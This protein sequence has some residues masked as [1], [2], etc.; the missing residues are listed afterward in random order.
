MSKSLALHATNCEI[1]PEVMN[2]ELMK[3]E[4]HGLPL[5]KLLEICTNRTLGLPSRAATKA[6][7]ERL[8]VW[9]MAEVESAE[10]DQSHADAGSS[11]LLGCGSDVGC[12]DRSR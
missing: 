3:K 7:S 12:K 1:G 9:I 10:S 5:S 11:L 6:P 4:P 2:P 8:N